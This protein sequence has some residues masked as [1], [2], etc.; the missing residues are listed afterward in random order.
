MPQTRATGTLISFI[1]SNRA[2]ARARRKVNLA[3]F[4]SLIWQQKKTRKS[5]NSL[6]GVA[7]G[8][9]PGANFEY[10]LASVGTNSIDTRKPEAEQL[11]DVIRG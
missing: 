11:F 7:S 2:L 10:P 1:F 4:N 3:N 6:A 5:G 8:E 9:R